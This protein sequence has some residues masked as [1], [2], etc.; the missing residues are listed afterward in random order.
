MSG[1]A[2][3]SAV[4]VWLSEVDRGS[5]IAIARQAAQ[6]GEPL[7]EPA[8]GFTH[9]LRQMP[10]GAVVLAIALGVVLLNGWRPR[11]ALSW[12]PSRLSVHRWCRCGP[13]V[14][15]G[16]RFPDPCHRPHVQ[17][18]RS[19]TSA[20]EQP[21]PATATASLRRDL[22]VPGTHRLFLGTFAD[23]VS[24]VQPVLTGLHQC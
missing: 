21:V 11:P 19:D 2:V 14:F 16:G 15:D 8:R 10:T 7:D 22:V 3:G 9:R 4:V 13:D 20:R 23:P 17:V 1:T 6:P 5:T 24:S 18:D 12:Q